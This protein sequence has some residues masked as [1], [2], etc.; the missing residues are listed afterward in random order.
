ME[1]VELKEMFD[2]EEN[3][4]LY[5]VTGRGLGERIMEEGLLVEGTNILNASNII[6]TTT[7][8]ITKEIV[9]NLENFV[10]DE[11]KN[12]SFRDSSE[13]VILG[14]PKEYK[15][16]IVDKVRTSKENMDFQ[17]RVSDRYVMGYINQG[18][19]F[20]PNENFEYGTDEFY[21]N[22]TCKTM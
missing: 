14:S 3:D 20:V 9:D 18:L 17:G 1:L 7:L 8:P 4:Y 13:M 21:D 11:L 22:L 12:K 10:A 16:Q 5:H 2:F 6:E 15:K 19:E